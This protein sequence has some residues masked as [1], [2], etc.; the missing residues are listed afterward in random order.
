MGDGTCS[1]S[2]RPCPSVE[3]LGQ[4]FVWALPAALG[5][6][7]NLESLRLS[8]NPLT[9]P[10]PAELSNLSNLQTLKLGD[11]QLTGPIP[12]ELGNLANLFTLELGGNQLTGWVS[13]SA[14][15]PNRLQRWVTGGLLSAR[16]PI[17]SEQPI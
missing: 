6:L 1:R 14:G 15:I 10:I 3:P 12:S 16:H 5:D 9:G 4:Q 8:D 2:C 7:S 13:R 11:N 17:V